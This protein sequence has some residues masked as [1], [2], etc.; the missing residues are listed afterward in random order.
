MKG[1]LA[2]PDGLGVYLFPHPLPALKNS[3]AFYLRETRCSDLVC[4]FPTIAGK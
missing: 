3:P 4:V 2:N 1:R